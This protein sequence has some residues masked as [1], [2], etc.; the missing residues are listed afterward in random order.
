MQPPSR[1][2]YSKE[3]AQCPTGE[4]KM[5][6]T[7]L[8][9][10]LRWS[11]VSERK[12][13][14]A[15]K[16]LSRFFLVPK[17][18]LEVLD[19][20]LCLVEGR[21]TSRKQKLLNPKLSFLNTWTLFFSPHQQF[22]TASDIHTPEILE[23]LKHSINKSNNLL[24]AKE[25]VGRV[26]FMI[27]CGDKM[28]ENGKV[29]AHQVNEHIKMGALDELSGLPFNWW[30]IWSKHV[31]SRVQRMKRQVDGSGND[32]EEPDYEDEYGDEDDEVSE[33]LRSEIS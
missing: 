29:I 19:F 24:N 15:I 22:I 2:L 14:K 33:E 7:L 31:K 3:I 13:E 18:S 23:M 32:E 17:V 5:M 26:E 20:W 25:T 9:Q 11:D 8:L 1:Y 21:K 28:F 6:L 4:S 30:N 16:K 27:G 10:S 12:K